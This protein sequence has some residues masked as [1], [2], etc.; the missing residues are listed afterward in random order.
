VSN[1]SRTME[2]A[3]TGIEI[4]VIGMAGRFP[5]AN[6]LNE[7]WRN[8]KNGVEGISVFS[9]NELRE[10][11]VDEET[12]RDPSYV[13]A[14][15]II[16]D[17]SL[18]DASFFDY[19]P[20]E[21]EIMDP[22]VRVFTECVWEALEHAGYE[23]DQ[24]KGLIGLYA[25]ASPSFYWEGLT[26]LSGRSNQ[27]GDYATSLLANRDY[28]CTRV[29][30]NL[31][32]RG[33]SYFV[34]SACSTSLVA[35]HLACRAL[36]TGEC[37]MALAG[38]ISLTYVP[39]RGYFYREGLVSSPDGHCRAFDANARG[40]VFGDG[41]GV[42]VLKRLKNALADG[43]SIQA[44]IKGSAIN[45]DGRR[46]VGF[47]APSIEG[48]AEVIRTALRLA[49]VEPESISYVEA[50]G[51]GTALGDPV[52]I[53][54]LKLAFQ[55]SWT[56]ACGIGSVKTNLGH[57]DTA[58]GVAGF[59]KTVLALKHR[60][61]PP[62][63]HFQTNNPKIDFDH[64]PFYV[65]DKPT[66]WA[67]EKFPLRAG[68]SS[69]GIGGTNAHIILE[70]APD[71]TS[72]T[73]VRPFELLLFSAKS[74][75]ALDKTT[76]NL[77]QFLKENPN[78]K[79]ADVAYTLSLGRKAL[80]H[81]RI[82][83]CADTQDA[84]TT[85]S[86]ND[87]GKLQTYHAKVENRPV[88]FMFPG[89]GSQYVNMGRE[90]YQSEPIFRQEL[91]RCFDLLEKSTG[92]ELKSL[93]Y[94]DGANLDSEPNSKLVKTEQVQPL[95]FIFEY[96]LTKLLMKLG[97]TPHAMIG[98]S[99]GEYVAACLS[100]VFSLEDAL[101][102][103]AARASLMQNMASG[104][105]LSVAL[106]ERD[107]A[108][109][110]TNDVELAAVNCN[111][112]CVL[113]GSIHAIDAFAETLQQLGQQYTR[114]HT[115]HAFH[116]QMMEPMLVEFRE[117]LKSVVLQRPQLPYISNL[118]GTWIT[119]EEATSPTYWLDHLRR[120][121]RFAD[122]I[123][124]LLKTSNAIF[125]EVGPGLALSTFVRQHQDKKPDQAIT[126]LIKHPKEN[127]SD[128]AFFLSKLGQL[129]LWGKDISWAELYS[130]QNRRRIPLP[131]YPF[132][133]QRYWIDKEFD[134][135]HF[136]PK[137][138][139]T[140]LTDIKDWFYIPSWKRVRVPALPDAT[141]EH[142]SFLVFIDADD[143]GAELVK[144][145]QQAG[146]RVATVEAGQKFTKQADGIY[147]LNP[148]NGN[149]YIALFND[150]KAS[151]NIPTTIVHLWTVSNDAE[152]MIDL[153]KFTAVQDVG[154]YGL[155][156]IARSLAEC[157]INDEIQIKVIT[158]NMQGVAG[159]EPLHPEKAT[160]LG[161]VKTI[162]Q[163]YHNLKC[164]VIDISGKM[165]RTLL[166]QLFVESRTEASNKV[167]A[168]RG[169]FCW[170]QTYEPVKLEKSPTLKSRLKPRGVY[171]LTGG[172]GGIALVLAEYLAKTVHAKLILIGRSDFPGKDQW[173]AWL[174][175]HDH[176]DQISQKILKLQEFE[177]AGSEVLVLQADVAN[178]EQMQE[179]IALSLS[180]FGTINGVIHCAGVPDGRAMQLRTRE[181]TDGI[182]APKVAGT[183]ILDK[184]L[185]NIELDFLVL[186]SS[187][188]AVFPIFGQVG[189]C[190]ANAFLDSFAQ[191]KNSKNGHFA[192]SINWDTWEEVGMAVNA[193][194][195]TKPNPVFETRLQPVAHPLFEGY[196]LNG[197]VEKT[198]I[199]K[200]N[201]RK[202]WILDEHRVLNGAATFPGTGYLEMLRA[203]FDE[204]G[205]QHG[206]EIRDL[207]FLM[208]LTLT[209]N[210]ERE[211]RTVVKR[212]D[213]NRYEATI[214]SVS[215]LESEPLTIHARAEVSSL[216]PVLPKK[217]NLQ[218]IA[219]R[220]RLKEI[221]LNL[222]SS[223]T[224]GDYGPRW[225]CCKWIK[226]GDNEGLA[227]LESPN[228]CA[229]DF[230]Y[231]KLHPALMD[232]CTG[233]LFMLGLQGGSYLPFS[234]S[235]ISIKN[236]LPSKVFSYIRFSKGSQPHQKLLSFDITIL[237]EAGFEVVDIKGYTFKEVNLDRPTEPDH[238]NASTA[239][240]ATAAAT[241]IR[242]GILPVEGVEVFDRILSDVLPQV[243]V[244]TRDL[245]ARMEQQ[246]QADSVLSESHGSAPSAFQKRPDLSTEYVAPRN[247]AEQKVAAIW[248]NF[249]GFEQIGIYDDFF[250]LGGDSLR[251]MVITS[252]IHKE[253]DIKI[254]LV[255]F[256]KKPNIAGLGEFFQSADVSEFSF[257]KAV[258]KKKFYSLS[259]AQERLYYLE[260]LVG[261]RAVYNITEVYQVLGDLDIERLNAVFQKLIMRHESL[262]TSIAVIDAEPVQIIH[263]E[264]DFQLDYREV[265]EDEVDAIVAQFRRPFDIA[266]APFLRV[267]VLKLAP[268][269]HILMF[270]LYHIIADGTSLLILMKEFHSL[271]YGLDLPELKIHYKDFSEW[272]NALLVS[273]AI[274]KQEEFW[275][276]TFSGELPVLAMP[277][278][279]PRPAILNYEGDYYEFELNE[280][281]S[282]RIKHM[283]AE[284]EVTLFMS[285]IALYN[286]LLAKFTGQEDIIVGTPVTGRHHADLENV[287]GMFV[288][289]VALRN[290]PSLNK[291]F[292][293][294]LQEVKE[295]TLKA[296]ENQ[297]YQLQ[298]LLSKLDL[299]KDFSRN[300]LF[301][302]LF[303]F[304]NMFVDRSQQQDSGLK[305]IPYK[306]EDR[307]AKF[308]IDIYVFDVGTKLTFNCSYR[309]SIF[310]P[311]SIKYLMGEYLR[312]IELVSQDLNK[313]IR[314]YELF[315]K[316]DLH[317]RK[318]K[319][320]IQP[321]L[322]S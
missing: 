247:D 118:S 227:Y 307:V 155:I 266:R 37:S 65:V 105:M 115:S 96:A 90:L 299:K 229:D 113:S 312:L 72:S 56:H 86:G 265:R 161:P 192:V 171:L 142:R 208:P 158:S 202:H 311:S 231:F 296:F 314:S 48:Q 253:W 286:V 49:R 127:I 306:F 226:L 157:G 156:N 181:M 277:T 104:A 263:D 191:Y 79:I 182:L 1:D 267:C 94:S 153:V 27:L 301:D 6:N 317:A 16:E 308:D 54:G 175:A 50:H 209:D 195:A 320:V 11:G 59:I 176:H 235:R 100:G 87:S 154:F 255:E 164:D 71:V 245:H 257:I 116:S 315:R 67:N 207:L 151:K 273:D 147:T 3:T 63:L 110:L 167:V 302:T 232:V 101:K 26:L 228:A 297:D 121:V 275:L 290:F 38:G 201:V 19:T 103:V 205:N 304:R 230:Q 168:Y 81:R 258:E 269:K 7:F 134:A 179:A 225:N 24:Y 141:N 189:Y 243:V 220:C 203:A 62:N 82:I 68:V 210:E 241:K 69:F 283:S 32:L 43:D 36:L 109:L 163:E 289:A 108:P 268:D 221:D 132:E 180:R 236:H 51:T 238:S 122:G 144:R 25:G 131:T 218:E 272:Q 184:L 41:V 42:V 30:Y 249:F 213:N 40:T 66:K 29:S 83:V 298:M 274:K 55:S 222:D 172:L 53:E 224:I 264:V 211:V 196:S 98:H 188:N 212:T 185:E 248:K 261:D 146:H 44:V 254:P 4:A 200:L 135:E 242:S 89:Q 215:H 21:A 177:K 52:E 166:E 162:P 45:N 256:F 136:A 106:S 281:V 10:A 119:V 75:S 173:Q 246:K 64:G 160:V 20:V 46:K 84:I 284:R 194:R 237:D 120:T 22:Q 73:S 152:D 198:Y 260:Q 102:L 187:L 206:L 114:L 318:N 199:S 124:E 92:K 219:Q 148:E 234:Y 112:L 140:K 259:S 8:L 39:K 9:D 279:Y 204:N 252:R 316:T 270:D 85:L 216:V 150:L 309:T 58:A 214:A 138:R 305:F 99:I 295:N 319:V 239:Q 217:H 60:L 125:L 223:K 12:L 291:I 2:T 61:I 240:P 14:R 159:E 262:R 233:F 18:F 137:L 35:I 165:N 197:N 17:I 293:D 117:V 193:A 123:A 287:I 15:G 107:L 128:Y 178:F 74:K 130:Q 174:E 280:E 97:I 143:I 278:D 34:Q 186:C 313:P 28:M 276:Q 33:P 303:N 57:T 183:L 139:L 13:K 292:A 321:N 190:A 23:P 250:E 271:Y 80:N 5:G 31:N 88:M 322:S 95:I 251:V 288:N 244:S 300:P 129:W 170:V 310:S 126:T 149:D 78:A 282:A 169:N 133:R 93:L 145:L 285:L 77:A 47:S 91:D 294:F 76:A 70:E 111:A